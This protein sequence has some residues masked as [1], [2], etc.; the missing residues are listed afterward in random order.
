MATEKR[1]AA[2]DAADIKNKDAEA[3]HFLAE[4]AH[5]EL[6]VKGLTFDFERLERKSNVERADDFNHGYFRWVDQVSGNSVDI[7]LTMLRCYCRVHENDRKKP[8]I[9]I[10]LNS[11]GGSIIDGFQLFDEVTR[12]RKQGYHI[13]IRVRGMAASMASVLLQA[14]DVREIGPNANLMIH[15][16]AFGAIGKA[17]EI[18]DEVEF[19]KKLEASI[20]TIFS[21][22]SGK[23]RKVFED[24][25]AKR[26][27]LWF[28]S[29]ET[30][31]FGL[32]D[33]II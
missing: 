13:T 11:P 17:Y 18:E 23:K 5:K 1:N 27:D 24:L 12:F 16:A 14:A 2:V 32:A 19:V 7:W 3:R 10:E 33:A 15:R 4:A 26:K 25:L 30:L 28:T 22:R 9:V 21:G 6:I 29:E 20:V 31:K 8:R